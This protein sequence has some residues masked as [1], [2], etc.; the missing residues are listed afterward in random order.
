MR[1]KICGIYMV[2]NT[3]NG[4]C[5]IGQSKDIRR[6]W[7]MHK[8]SRTNIKKL[9]IVGK[10]MKEFG[11]NNFK[12][13]ILEECSV[14]VLDER[15]RHYI[16]KFNP[17]Y[18]VLNGGKAGFEVPEFIRDKCR[19]GALKQWNDMSED[20]RQHVITHQLKGPAVGH[21]VSEETR[22]KLRQA[23]LGKKQTKET[24]EKRIASFQR[25]GYKPKPNYKKCRCVETGEIFDSVQEAARF[26][27]VSPAQ[28]SRALNGKIKTSGGYHWEKLQQCRD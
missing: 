4:D 24:V 27:N 10:A 16:A 18:N 9:P 5:Y 13:E 2:T 19:Q 26:A 7:W 8:G 22:A 11:I 17:T 23:N 15:E 25:V 3:I 12:L 28:V 14:D 6:R 20:Q 21:E 1:N